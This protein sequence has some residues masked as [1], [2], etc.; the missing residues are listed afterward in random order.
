MEKKEEEIE[1]RKRDQDSGILSRMKY[2]EES[3][4][5]IIKRVYHI[6]KNLTNLTEAVSNIIP[7]TRL[8]FKAVKPEQKIQAQEPL[9][10]K[11][12]SQPL[13]VQESKAIEPVL[14]KILTAK[15]PNQISKPQI[16]QEIKPIQP[17]SQKISLESIKQLPKYKSKQ[18]KTLSASEF[19]PYV[20][21]FAFYL[22]LSV[23]I[24]IGTRFMIDWFTEEETSLS[25]FIYIYIF[26]TIFI[27]SGYFVHRTLEKKH[28]K[29][30][31]IF[32]QSFII[33]GIIGYFLS[34]FLP[35][36]IISE[37]GPIKYIYW[38]VVLG[39]LIITLII[40]TKILYNEF[41]I[42]ECYL[43]IILLLFIPTVLDPSFFG[44]YSN[45]I[46][47][48]LFIG[49][50]LGGF[51]FGTMGVSFTPAIITLICLSIM[52]LGSIFAEN[53][54]LI[55]V[56]LAL[57]GFSVSWILNHEISF[58]TNFYDNKISNLVIFAISQILP[59]IGIYV[60][61][62]KRYA[63]AL[64][65]WDL[66]SS[67]MI[68][69]CTYFVLLSSQKKKIGKIFE[70]S[71]QFFLLS[72]IFINILFQL[73]L[74]TITFFPDLNSFEKSAFSAIWIVS[75]IGVLIVSLKRIS[76]IPVLLQAVLIPLMILS[77]DFSTTI[78]F[79]LLFL[80][81]SSLS[82]S[83]I[84][85]KNYKIE[86]S[87]SSIM[88]NEKFIIIA[89]QIV[90][91]LSLS[92]FLF[93]GRI[94]DYSSLEYFSC[95]FLF[96]IVQ[97][98]TIKKRRENFETKFSKL[99]AN[100][101]VFITFGANMIQIFFG[102][103]SEILFSPDYVI[104]SQNYIS[105]SV[106]YITPIFIFYTC[107]YF[108]LSYVPIFGA[109][110]F[111]DASNIMKISFQSLGLVLSQILFIINAMILQNEVY[112]LIF[113]IITIGHLLLAIFLPLI[114][115][116]S[117]EFRTFSIELLLLVIV[118]FWIIRNFFIITL[119]W[120]VYLEI[121][122]FFILIGL[123]IFYSIIYYL[124]ESEKNAVQLFKQWSNSK[125][126]LAEL[127]VIN[128][129]LTLIYRDLLIFSLLIIS[130]MIS[131]VFAILS[132]K[133]YP[134]DRNAIVDNYFI[135]ILA[136]IVFIICSFSA[137]IFLPI[138]FL[139]FLITSFLFMMGIMY[140]TSSNHWVE[141]TIYLAIQFFISNY[142]LNSQNIDIN[143]MK[144]VVLGFYGIS[145]IIF[146]Y[147]AYKY[148][149]KQGQE[150][151]FSEINLIWALHFYIMNHD[152]LSN[153]LILFPAL[154]LV[155]GKIGLEM[156]H[157]QKSTESETLV[158]SQSQIKKNLVF[159]GIQLLVNIL[160]FSYLSYII[161]YLQ[162]NIFP[163]NTVIWINYF[164]FMIFFSVNIPFFTQS[165]FRSILTLISPMLIFVV[166]IFMHW[167]PS[168]VNYLFFI[169]SVGYAA[170]FLMN[171]KQ[172]NKESENNL[173]LLV[174]IYF[175][176]LLTSISCILTEFPLDIKFGFIFVFILLTLY[177]NT[178][179]KIHK[180]RIFQL[181][182]ISGVG[183]SYIVYVLINV[184][185]PG[186]H[187]AS[188]IF[189]LVGIGLILG[190]FIKY[191]SNL[192]EMKEILDENENSVKHEIPR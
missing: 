160:V 26:A 65:I 97:F 127:I 81:L 7:E 118:D 42:G 152:Y 35:I 19:I 115:P 168:Y 111:S 40:V 117:K 44:T 72:A 145:S 190:S 150:I 161:S 56:L 23:T 22:L 96:Q 130:L 142:L 93:Q 167:E 114:S 83:W 27:L 29:A 138:A 128:V 11:P 30:Y 6:E 73:F 158:N 84:Q 173:M 49:I 4:I 104:M 77:I 101:L 170:I 149:P 112:A 155:L 86:E 82:L 156:L 137:D 70:K 120:L 189:L 52:C 79:P 153:L 32:P 191:R 107:A 20:L 144:W 164:L 92:I 15:V 90:V 25:I 187:Y 159:H 53:V 10:F 106:F 183:F 175:I 45:V 95:I 124:N 116:D 184:G 122:V 41:F 66:I 110:Y 182:L 157:V 62:T 78:Y 163:E 188:L 136:M 174:E 75:L 18:K 178:M 140:V 16:K 131:I 24:Y 33:V 39:S 55:I 34:Y 64:P 121:A 172:K 154:F 54:S 177:L 21:L 176:I 38:V 46:L 100:I 59:N 169:L 17:I 181:L 3:I 98:L 87:P 133:R 43:F 185:S 8:E 129:I 68:I 91:T 58:K 80:L 61:I 67:A 69:Q 102:A 88:M 94:S 74:I 139:I 51:L 180:A 2:L 99:D 179:F 108:I 186:F 5:S 12:I 143:I 63:L 76:E 36:S 192:A 147:K 48:I 134:K 85:H 141:T 146:L 125:L 50:I 113:F 105:S 135:S 47:T 165:K 166:E 132:I 148:N 123:T 171:S 162:I 28:L 71:H 57:S 126:I 9:Q 1:I 151:I 31:M 13:K 14:S 119:P 89:H 103:I 109:K 60:L 37:Q